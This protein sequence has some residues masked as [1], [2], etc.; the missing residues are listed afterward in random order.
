MRKTG[1][2]IAHLVVRSPDIV[3]CEVRSA[4]ALSILTKNA[5][6]VVG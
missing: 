2:A 6:A 5:I 3:E 1:R 4:I